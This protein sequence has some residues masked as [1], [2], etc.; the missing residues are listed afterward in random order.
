ML[1]KNY[2]N[3]Q[4]HKPFILISNKSSETNSGFICNMY[5]TVYI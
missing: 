3:E 2:D 1:Y 4:I 5:I